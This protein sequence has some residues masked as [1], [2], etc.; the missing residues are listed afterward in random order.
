MPLVSSPPRRRPPYSSMLEELADDAEDGIAGE[1]GAADHAR[2][3]QGTAPVRQ[4]AQDEEQSDPFEGRLVELAWMARQRVPSRERP[5]P[6][7]HRF[8]GR[9][10]RH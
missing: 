2:R 6:R 9:R 7:G 4:P 10:P 5:W 3:R 1:E 8:R